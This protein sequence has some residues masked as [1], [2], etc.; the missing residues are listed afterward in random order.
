[1]FIGRQEELKAIQGILERKS[2]SVLVYGKRKVGKTTLILEALKS[3]KDTTVYYECLKSSMQDNIN[4]FVSVLVKIKVLPVQMGF[5]SFQEVFQYLNTLDK[6]LNIIIDEY[7][8]LKQFNKGE[9][10]DSIFQTIIDNNITNIRLF[11]SGSHVGMMKDLLEEKNALYGRFSLNIK[12]KEL[13]YRETAVF[14]N[15]KTAYDKIAFYSVFGGSPFVNEQLDVRADLKQNILRTVLNPLNAVYSY[16]EN[17]L[18]SDLSG[19]VNAERILNV[20]ANGRKKYGEIESKLGLTNNGLLSK[21]LKTLLDM[22]MVSKVY[23]INKEDDNKKV[24]YEMTDNLLRFWYTYVYKNKSALQMLGAEAFYDNYIEPS[25]TTFISHRVEEIAR[26][27]FSLQVKEGKR[28]GIFRIGTYYYD[29]SA[30]KTNGEF[31]VVLQRKDNYDIYEV[32]YYSK[33]LSLKEM[34][35]EEEQIRNIKGLAV[36]TI[37]FIS[38]NGFENLSSKYECV[39]GDDLY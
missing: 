19:S 6:T 18:V 4:G 28:K 35:A 39:S 5:S 26:T 24:S 23:P 20:I 36:G 38:V 1:M 21:Q 11:I 8:Y 22:D 27:F 30:T 3:S 33:P 32:K 31:D 7:P 9:T 12:L 16:A 17:L 2:G 13:N 34:Q 10:V 29:D 25:I 14:Y 15:D 37:G